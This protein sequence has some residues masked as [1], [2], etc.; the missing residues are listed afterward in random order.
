MTSSRPPRRPASKRSRRRTAASPRSKA[1]LRVESLEPRQLLTTV[2]QFNTALGS[3]QVEMFDDTPI[4][5]QNFLNYAQRGAYDETIVHRS[6]YLNATTPFVV[7]GGG[8]NINGPIPQ[9]APIAN[10]YRHSNV[11]GTIAMAKR[12]GDPHSA[13]NQWFFN[14]GDNSANLDNQNGGFTVFGRVMGSGMQIVDA[15]AAVP[16]FNK[17]NG[18][19][20]PA[21]LSAV[22]GELSELPLGNYSNNPTT[23]PVT[24]ANLLVIDVNAPPK[25]V[26][27][28]PLRVGRGETLTVLGGQLTAIDHEQLPT[29]VTYVITRGPTHGS[30]RRAG[31]A[32]NSFTQDDL[33][34]NRITYV[35]D[36][37]SAAT[38]S[39]EFRV[40]DGA[41]SSVGPHTANIN[42]ATD[43]P[44]AGN[45]NPLTLA[46]G[47]AANITNTLLSTIDAD[48]SVTRLVYTVVAQPTQGRLLVNG[49]A[50]S[51]FTQDDINQ[52]RVRYQHD[53]GENLSDGFQFTVSDGFT[54]LPQRT[55]AINITPVNDLPTLNPP[56]VTRVVQGRQVLIPL[57][58]QDAET[59]VGQLVV[60]MD[61]T[62][63]PGAQ[64]VAAAR[65]LLWNV[66]QDQ[67]VG[68]YRFTFRVRDANQPPGETQQLVTVVV[69]EPNRPP[70][71]GSL[72]DRLDGE[73]HREVSFRAT[74][75]D[76]NRPAQ[77]LRFSLVN[78]PTGASIDAVTGQ[79]LWTPGEDAGGQ[80]VTLVVRV[81]DDG[82][83]PLSDQRSITVDVAERNDPPLLTP[84]SLQVAQGGS[85]L[86]QLA[87]TD[88]DTPSGLLRYELGSGAPAGLEIDPQTGL[89]SWDTSAG[90]TL[91]TYDLLIGIRDPQGLTT[92]VQAQI[93]VTPPFDA[94]Q[95]QSLTAATT[96]AAA[97]LGPVAPVT[98]IAFGIATSGGT[99]STGT[100]TGSS[101]S[102]IFSNAAPNFTIGTDTGVGRINRS[103][104][105]KRENKETPGKP[106]E[107]TST[108]LPDQV[109]PRQQAAFTAKSLEPVDAAVAAVEDWHFD[110]LLA[111][112]QGKP[113]A[114]A[115]IRF[116]TAVP[117][118]TRT[119]TTENAPLTAL[120][121]TQLPATTAVP[122]ATRPTAAVPPR[123]ASASAQ[124]SKTSLS[125]AA[126]VSLTLPLL[127]TDVR[128]TLRKPSPRKS[129]PR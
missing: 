127:V 39:F 65:Q 24:S 51:T 77:N 93:T 61:G 114:F 83:N 109:T 107:G 12:G 106:N 40:D 88:P 18:N 62:L 96:S 123:A 63:P 74:A 122:A 111:T 99:S 79:F 97:T 37:S 21:G 72:P 35:H 3:F 53:G 87:A 26:S 85:I 47:T 4:T 112:A 46:E 110:L 19:G 101:E 1:T 17:S 102:S 38:D 90:Q 82:A 41:G 125:T 11:R 34:N 121:G 58:V 27:N 42:I 20:L 124:S 7:Q 94:A 14:M 103:K 84:F 126:A 129:R 100:A 128:P 118:V 2:V 59:P 104:K 91:G 69:E 116:R 64:F 76:P 57:N 117:A 33:D 92:T 5:T 31:V 36:R 50:A 89:L 15:L 120:P 115:R 8:N 49:Q 68:E 75:S 6:A 29:A 10:E 70:Q 30:L 95:F 44:I 108:Q 25:L 55:F 22:R 23:T 98:Q 52:N 86:F 78:A 56:P 71:L 67:A 16:R 66:P 9:D 32:V 45:N 43:A 28:Q 81:T 105:T 60:S 13:T 48:T 80:S 113:E 73:E 119:A 54:G